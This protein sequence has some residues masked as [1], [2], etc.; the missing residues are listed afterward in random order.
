[1]IEISGNIFNVSENIV[2]TTN[3]NIKKNGEAVMGKGLA[4]KAAKLI[5]TLPKILGDKLLDGNNVYYL[6]QFD[7]F[8]GV[9]NF[10]TKH[11]WWEK[12]DLQLILRSCKQLI[13]LVNIMQ[14]PKI[15]L[16]RPG[17]GFGQLSW[18]KT[19][20]PAIENLFD[21]RFSVISL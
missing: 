15:I 6:G 12:S 17:C 19:I 1:M 3:G 10:P 11:N 21:D 13:E 18:N 5:P 9:F 16:P 2:I 8:I 4:L 20:K 14:I 7:K